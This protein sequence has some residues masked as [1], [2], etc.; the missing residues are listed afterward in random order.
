QSQP[1]AARVTQC[2]IA[3]FQVRNLVDG[4]KGL[5][6]LREGD[7]TGAGVFFESVVYNA[8]CDILECREY[9]YDR[10]LVVWLNEL[11]D[12]RK[13]HPRP[14][15]AR[16]PVDMRLDKLLADFQAQTPRAP[17]LDE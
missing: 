14:P 4:M 11:A 10:R 1:A 15:E 17:R 2:D 7:S 8:A 3:Q 5:R 16:T 12:Y 6:A 9:R 13:Q